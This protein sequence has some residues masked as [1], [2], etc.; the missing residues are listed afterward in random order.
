[1]TVVEEHG[2]IVWKSPCRLLGNE[3]D[4]ADC[5]FARQQLIR[6]WTALLRDWH[7]GA[8]IW[9]DPNT[10][11]SVR[12]LIEPKKRKDRSHSIEISDF[13]WNKKLDASLFRIPED[14]TMV[15]AQRWM[16]ER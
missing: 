2:W 1:M 9:V 13:Q 5:E 6:H 14:Y 10:Q 3:A 8:K 12:I 7:G 11:L 4:V 16:R 15:D